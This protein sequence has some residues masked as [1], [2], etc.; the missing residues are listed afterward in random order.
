MKFAAYRPTEAA[1]PL[2]LV[3]ECM[4][5]TISLERAVE[6]LELLGTVEL[7]LSSVRDISNP[8]LS[9]EELNQ[10]AITAPRLARR[11]TLEVQPIAEPVCEE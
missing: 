11:V 3:P 8:A 1:Y 6:A 10:F 2:V 9:D 7:S 5:P 4:T